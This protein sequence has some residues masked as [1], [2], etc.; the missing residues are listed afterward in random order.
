VKR[1]HAPS[2]KGDPARGASG[3]TYPLSL[4][5]IVRN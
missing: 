4:C 3:V 2:G 5:M 1:R